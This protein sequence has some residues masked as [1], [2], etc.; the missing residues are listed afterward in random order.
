ME[1]GCL[2]RFAYL[3]LFAGPRVEYGFHYGKYPLLF[4][5]QGAYL[6]LLHIQLLL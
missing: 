1:A 6:R 2:P 3:H 4:L 5:L